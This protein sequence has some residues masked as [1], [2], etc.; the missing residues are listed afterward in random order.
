M[1]TFCRCCLCAGKVGGALA[2]VLG[3]YLAVSHGFSLSPWDLARWG[4]ELAAA[5]ERDEEL[6]VIRRRAEVRLAGKC[7]VI[8]DVRAD[9]LGLLEAA[10]FTVMEQRLTAGD[11]IVIYSDGV[12]EAQNLEKRFFGKKRLREV[13]EAHAGQSCVAIHDAVQEAVAAFTEGAAQ[14]DDITLVV[15][16]FWGAA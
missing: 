7:V 3:L 10:E 2:V 13:V 15:L 5:R 12:T 14:S 8:A 4:A 6:E 9:R 1:K 11:K 16:E